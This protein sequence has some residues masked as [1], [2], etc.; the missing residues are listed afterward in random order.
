M[1]PYAH[2]KRSNWIE[3]LSHPFGT[4]IGAGAITLSVLLSIQ[5]ANAFG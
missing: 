3:S 4:T 2:K 1:A 5:T